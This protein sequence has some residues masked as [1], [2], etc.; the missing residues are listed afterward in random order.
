M[1]ILPHKST[2]SYA[3]GIWLVYEDEDISLKFWASLINGKEKFYVNDKLYSSK[4]NVTKFRTVDT[5]LF[6]DKEYDVEFLT[7]YSATPGYECNIF[8]NGQYRQTFICRTLITGEIEIVESSENQA[9]ID[10]MEGQFRKKAL[11]CLKE[12]ELPE[13]ITAFKKC[14][15]INPSNGET[16]FYIA[17]ALSLQEEKEEGFNFLRKALENKMPGKNRV[18]EEDKLAYLRLQPEFDAIKEAYF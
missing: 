5:I 6:E 2:A 4:R 9:S 8:K 16:Q 13:A 7:K 12:Y 17:C 3:K 11:K 14:L 15:Q 10:R 18:L 1:E